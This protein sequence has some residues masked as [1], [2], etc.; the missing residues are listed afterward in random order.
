MLVLSERRRQFEN[1][2]PY[3][4]K[5]MT[6]WH[7]KITE[8]IN[9]ERILIVGGVAHILLASNPL[10][11]DDDIAAALVYIYGIPLFAI[12]DAMIKHFYCNLY[13]TYQSII[14]E[15]KGQ[16]IYY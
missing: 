2:K 6:S 1:E 8:I 3:M 16:Q 10:S 15:L 7:N 13:E 5:R 4:G 12:N 14:N 11:T 9:F